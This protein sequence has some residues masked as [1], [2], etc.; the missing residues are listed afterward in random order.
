MNYSDYIN[1]PSWKKKRKV[2]LKMD[3][4]ACRLCDE[5]GT[6]YRL[7]VHHRPSSYEKI[8]NESVRD[9]LVT[10]CVRC[11]EMVT[12]VIREDRYNKREAIPIDFENR[13]IPTRNGVQHG[14]AKLEI[15]TD[16]G[17][18]VHLAQRANGRPAKQVVEVTE[19]DFVKARKNR[20]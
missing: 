20:R 5:D 2:R 16:I 4:Y 9:D 19:T 6:R 14:L 13:T 17:S 8:P 11:H 12:D 3:G 18:P 10:L 15:Q 7:E 1:S